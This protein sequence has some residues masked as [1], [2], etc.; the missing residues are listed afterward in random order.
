MT[1]IYKCCHGQTIR[2]GKAWTDQ[3]GVTHPANW[4]TYSAE[5][6]AELGITEIVQQ[7]HPDSRLYKWSYNDDGTVTSTAK[8]LDDINEVDENGDPLLDDD[9]VQVVTKGVKSK[10][11]A[12]V[13]SQQGALLAQSDW[14]VIRKADTNI[15]VPTNI[16]QWRNEIRLAA[17][18][19]EDQITQAATT[20]A[21]AALFL[22][23]TLEDDG[24]TTKSGVLYDWPELSE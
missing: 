12:G 11:I 8:S 23:Y 15:D 19:M 5:R 21:V 16:Q 13:K 17:A 14:A 22:T 18:A 3:T 10:L 9:G 20:D 2:P 7:P 4:H 6:K 1:T 24:T